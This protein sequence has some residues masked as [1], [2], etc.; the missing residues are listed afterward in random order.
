M[1]TKKNAQMIEVIE[2]LIACV[3]SLLLI[4]I[5][6]ILQLT[7]HEDEF[8]L[9]NGALIIF[10]GMSV[11]LLLSKGLAKKMQW[12]WIAVTFL[13]PAA[14]INLLPGTS[15]NDVVMLSSMHPSSPIYSA[16]WCW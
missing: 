10:F 5:P 8:Y 9:K 1:E 2:L 4:K 7:A 15:K 6:A 11:Y 14:F 16:H 13:I 12:I 3:I